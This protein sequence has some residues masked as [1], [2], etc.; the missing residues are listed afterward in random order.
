MNLAFQREIYQRRAP[1]T[2]NAMQG[3]VMAM[4][5]AINSR[6][7]KTLFGHDKGRISYEEFLEKLRAT[8]RCLVLDGLLEE[9]SDGA[10]A[11]EA[12]RGALQAFSGAFPNWPAAYQYAGEFFGDGNKANAIA[13]IQRLR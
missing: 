13:V 6:G 2:F 3:L 8:L 4:E 10:T 9:S 12:M 1:H 11:L 5:K 7:K